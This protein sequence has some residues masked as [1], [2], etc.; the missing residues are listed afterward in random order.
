MYSDNNHLKKNN[1][2]IST[3]SRQETAFQS[4]NAEFIGWQKTAEGEIFAIYNIIDRKHPRYRSTVSE[5]TLREL[6]LRIPATPPKPF[7]FPL[8]KLPEK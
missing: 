2:K 4:K 5:Y 6:N 8:F 3:K 1:S 7:S